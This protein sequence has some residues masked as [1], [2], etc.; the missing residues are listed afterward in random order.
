MALPTKKQLHKH[1][2]GTRKA[3]DTLEALDLDNQSSES[4]K[5][6]QKS[7]K[8]KAKRSV[9]VKQ[10][11]ESQAEARVLEGAKKPP[12][13]A[14][15]GGSG[16]ENVKKAE[17][18]LII[19]SSEGNGAI[20]ETVE[21][22]TLKDLDVSGRDTEKKTGETKEKELS[23]IELSRD[24]DE[25]T[26]KDRF[27]TFA[28]GPEEFGIEIKYVTEIIVMQ[29]I[30]EVPDTPDHIEG[31]INLR[32]KVIPVMD[33]R[34]RFGMENREYDERTC[35]IVVDFKEISVG[36]IVDTVSEVVDIPEGQIDPPP[37]SYA[38]IKSGYIQGMGKI[39][40]QVKILLNVEKVLYVGEPGS[41]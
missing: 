37:K 6:V 18:S 15:S 25:D 41:D 28:I 11:K 13:T 4:E 33:V 24:D 16:K 34:L 9:G 3:L 29:R 35:I 38:G 12:E 19:D 1:K 8:G 2:R 30:T 39:D 26:Q 14:D 22:K 27:L 5:K 23:R 17:D 31:V 20:K 21:V 40:K 7:D 32:G 10:K 36:L